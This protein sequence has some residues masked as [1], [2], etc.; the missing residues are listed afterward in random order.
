MALLV[1]SS[2]GPDVAGGSFSVVA[3]GVLPW[4]VKGKQLQVLL[5]HRGRYDDWSW[6]KGKLDAGE[7]VPECAVREAYEEIGLR[8][9]LGIPLPAI[10]YPVGSGPKVVYYWA[11]QVQDGTPVPD[12]VET[13]E[14]RWVSPEEARLMLTNASDAAPLDALVQAHE[15]GVLETRAFVVV[16]H[17]KAK[18]RSSWTLA[19][20]K[21]PL[22]ATGQ[23][24]ALAVADLLAAW[25]PKKIASSPW[26]RCM[27][28]VAPYANRNAV[29]V[30][31]VGELTE[32]AARRN[33][34]KA[35]RAIA[36]LL[37]KRRSQAVCTHRPVMPSVLAV[38]REQLP[39]RL[40][41]FLPAEDPYLRPG[42]VL[43]V[44]QPVA[45]PGKLVSVELYEP[46]ED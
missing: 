13:D 1:R 21:R 32:H 7:T 10:T 28:T 39:S 2:D 22:A 19:E 9:R 37:A 46:F 12:G 42:A 24:Q 38:L 4:R 20:G 45:T 18:P 44:Q 5:I 8:I 30:K 16:R 14:V 35:R 25:A 33:P 26:T 41:A 11:A 29:G 36:A 15:S 17:A 3:A 23:R 34:G 31:T 40:A 27:Q 43:V 6:P